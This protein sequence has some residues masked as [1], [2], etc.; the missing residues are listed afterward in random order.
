[1]YGTAVAAAGSGLAYTIGKTGSEFEQ[2]ITNVAAVGL[3]TR[4]EIGA[5]EAKALELGAKTK[6]TATQA[7]QGMEILRRA[8]FA[9]HEVLVG[10]SGVLDAAAASGLEMAEVA[11]HVS[12][13]LKG[14]GR[15]S[16][17]AAKAVK[18]MGLT[19]GAAAE[20]TRS[21]TMD[22]S[23][24]TRVADVLALASS[25]T[26]S[27]IGTLGESMRNV[28]ATARDLRVPFEDVVAGV[29]A[30]QD[31][32][33]DA[34]VAGSAMN[35]MLTKL[36]APT[37]ALKRKLNDL[38]VAF[39][40]S[41][42]NALPFIQ[43]LANLSKGGDKAGGTMKRVAFFS[44]LVGLRGQK[45]ASN[46]AML[47]KTG[48]FGK[49]AA[50]LRNAEGAAKKMAEIRMATLQGDLLKLGAAVDDVKIAFYGVKSGGLRDVV[51][52]ITAWVGANKKLAVSGFTTFVTKM[53]ELSKIFGKEFKAT[54]HGINE[55]FAVLAGGGDATQ[56]WINLLPELARNLGTLAA[57]S[58]SVL[59]TVGGLVAG[60]VVLGST[61]V[62]S[63]RA[64]FGA[65]AEVFGGAIHFITDWWQNIKSLFTAEGMSLGEKAYRIGKHIITGL[66]RGIEA[67]VKLPVEVARKV[68]VRV[69]AAMKRA[70]G[71]ASDSKKAKVVGAFTA[72]GFAAGIKTGSGAVQQAIDD[73]TAIHETKPITPT[74]RPTV[75]WPKLSPMIDPKIA[76]PS[77]QPKTAAQDVM[78][79][80]KT[81]A[82][83][84]MALPK[85]AAQ[86]VMALPKFMTV[87]APKDR[88]AGMLIRTSA[89][90]AQRTDGPER[91]QP[92]PLVVSPRSREGSANDA[93][94]DAMRQLTDAMR[95][96]DRGEL[97]IRDESGRAEVTRAPKGGRS[98]LRVQKSGEF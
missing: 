77:L 29:A 63:F 44:E 79:L 30:L 6:F 87:E 54:L 93:L 53:I 96:S 2:A 39:E 45:A 82:Q 26:N 35:T 59:S 60:M 72:S 71:I 25:R 31:V 19:G 40:D 65:I 12:N 51:Q 16:K 42:G 58:V 47:F 64:A 17:E 85:T 50:E 48:K 84:V 57:V 78:A 18:E 49:L 56:Q 22:A 37:A 7:A 43:I 34:S 80:P 8:G 69:L 20:M 5:L 91:L 74:I 90:P 81:A 98:R 10:V 1:M 4:K 24:A 3:Q 11:D 70:L 75:E 89:A 46:L 52:T 73:M 21:L 61:L 95:R 15:S 86:D 41:K 88:R 28:A 32:G 62:S 67:V 38:G 23:Q 14:M 83:D 92:T 9:S 36:A 97:V 76:W 94:V 33:L 55:G 13:V 66:V 27:T 68:G